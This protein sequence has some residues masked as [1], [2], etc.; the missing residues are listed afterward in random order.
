VVK[1]QSNTK[2]ETKSANKSEYNCVDS[3]KKLKTQHED[4]Y[5]NM[6]KTQREQ[7]TTNS[8]RQYAHA[9][10]N[11]T[12][13]LQQKRNLKTLEIRKELTETLTVEQ[14]KRILNGKSPFERENV[15]ILYFSGFKKNR[16][17]YIKIVLIKAGLAKDSI[18]N[19]SFIG[20]SVMEIVVRESMVEECVRVCDKVGGTMLKN[21]NPL[22]R[23]LILNIEN[24]NFKS[25]NMKEPET[26]FRERYL[27]MIEKKSGPTRLLQII[28]NS[29]IGDIERFLVNH[30]KIKIEYN[31]NDTSPAGEVLE[32]V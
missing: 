30:D 25:K 10:E 2:D 5:K 26:L 19:I 24:E 20:F 4:A 28:G 13:V 18:V 29:K 12:E 3:Y 15:K 6:M 14:A 27:K 11:K 22:K 31:L 7:N 21:F 32:N 23:N 8:R 17:S 9:E 1:K 16:I